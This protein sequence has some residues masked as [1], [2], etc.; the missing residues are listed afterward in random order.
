MSKSSNQKGFI[1]IPMLIGLLVFVFAGAAV[2]EV[3]EYREEIKLGIANISSSI[4]RSEGENNKEEFIKKQETQQ[5]SIIEDISTFETELTS[6]SD[7]NKNSEV[8]IKK[9]GQQSPKIVYKEI[10]KEII[11]EIPVSN[12]SSELYS[13]NELK[14]ETVTNTTESVSVSNESESVTD[15]EFQSEIEI[16]LNLCTNTTCSVCKY[17]D[18]GNCYNNCQVTDTNCGCNSCVDCNA[19]DGCFENNYLDYYCSDVFCAYTSDDCSDCSC[20]C[21][22]Y[23]IKENLNSENCSDGKDNDCDGFID[24]DD[25]QCIPSLIEPSLTVSIQDDSNDSYV[26]IAIT[27]NGDWDYYAG[28]PNSWNPLHRLKIKHLRLRLDYVTTT[29]E[30]IG[31]IYEGTIPKLRIDITCPNW[32]LHYDIGHS[33]LGSAV[34]FAENNDGIFDFILPDPC[35]GD[36]DGCIGGKDGAELL[37]QD[38]ALVLIKPDGGS[39]YIKEYQLTLLYTPESIIETA[40]GKD[41]PFFDLTLKPIN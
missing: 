22:G 31:T 38:I 37:P 24:S 11:K 4:F 10:V 21:G 8:E 6:T 1:Q 18:N 39:A 36:Y 3:I 17:C 9:Q 29:P 14:S 26:Y 13:K 2:V 27:N 41:I 20:F 33:Y 15:S 25:T 35:N 34:A 16:E 12:S 7:I 30:A 40:T 28:S 5:K 32:E 23:N 19:L